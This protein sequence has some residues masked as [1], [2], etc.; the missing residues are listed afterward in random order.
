LIEILKN[1]KLA[2]MVKPD[3]YPDQFNEMN[4]T[5]YAM[6]IR[7]FVEHNAQWWDAANGEFNRVAAI[8]HT[9]YGQGADTS[10]AKVPRD[11][12]RAQKLGRAEIATLKIIAD[13][14]QPCPYDTPYIERVEEDPFYFVLSP[15]R[16]LV[17][18]SPSE[19][20]AQ[21]KHNV[22]KSV[23][24]IALWEENIDIHQFDKEVDKKYEKRWDWHAYFD[25]LNFSDNDFPSLSN[26]A[27]EMRHL[28]DRYYPMNRSP[29][30]D[31]Q[32][33]HGD[34]RLPNLTLAVEQGSKVVGGI[35]DWGAARMGSRAEEFR[36]LYELGPEAIEA[37]N[38]ELEAQKQDLVDPDEIRF[39]F[40]SRFVCGLILHL[41]EGI[42]VKQSYVRSKAIVTSEYPNHDWS[43]LPVIE[44]TLKCTDN[45][46]PAFRYN[47]N[48]VPGLSLG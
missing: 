45:G 14:A 16:G 27:S 7:E 35:S 32:V 15:M 48:E 5:F 47:L 38:S 6:L 40:M 33:I 3:Q 10:L 22:G 29:A 1:Y 8:G 2:H 28:R 31:T 36:S 25:R 44:Q 12:D 18:S 37:A 34:L 41:N 24:R 19:L 17:L 4:N 43:E 39:W 26:A 9:P 23:A 21:E 20:V 11:T 46:A 30:L 42:P 13:T